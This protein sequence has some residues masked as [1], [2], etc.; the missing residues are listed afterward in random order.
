MTRKYS[1]RCELGTCPVRVMVDAPNPSEAARLLERRGWK[2]VGRLLA[3]PSCAS[4]PAGVTTEPLNRSG[5]P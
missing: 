5:L 3:C 2:F 1:V 4:K